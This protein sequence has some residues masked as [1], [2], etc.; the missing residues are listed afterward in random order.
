MTSKNFGAYFIIGHTRSGRSQPS[1]ADTKNI[2]FFAHAFN[3]S[4]THLFYLF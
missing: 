4:F 3:W 1:T 2:E